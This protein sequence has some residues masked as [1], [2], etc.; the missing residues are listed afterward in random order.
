MIHRYQ[1]LELD[2]F[3]NDQGGKKESASNWWRLEVET[4]KRGLNL[5][6][7]L[8]RYFTKLKII[9]RV[10]KISW[11]HHYVSRASRPKT[12]SKIADVSLWWVVACWLNQLVRVLKRQNWALSA[13]TVEKIGG[14]ESCKKC[15]V[16]HGYLTHICLLGHHR[17][18]C[19]QNNICLKV[20]TFILLICVQ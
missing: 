1:F 3:A 19:W 11:G 5:K 13:P 7:K 9:S 6:E 8:F 17:R 2:F 16:F 4:M 20:W 10:S 18:S 12:A 14:V 15:Q